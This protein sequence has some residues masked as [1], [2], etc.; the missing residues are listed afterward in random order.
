MREFESTTYTQLETWKWICPISYLRQNLQNMPHFYSYITKHF[1]IIHK[2]WI[3]WSNCVKD[4]EIRL[5]HRHLGNYGRKS[6][7]IR[8]KCRWQFC[9]EIYSVLVIIKIIF[10]VLALTLSYVWCIQNPILFCR[11]SGYW[12]IWRNHVLHSQTYMQSSQ[13]IACSLFVYVRSKR[14]K[15]IIWDIIKYRFVLS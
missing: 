10:P 8:A 1:R 6:V 12:I 5:A 14:L 4:K 9:R 7:T 13:K 15:C 11:N 3:L 2:H